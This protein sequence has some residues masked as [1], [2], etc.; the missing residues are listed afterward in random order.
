MNRKAERVKN[1]PAR[2]PLALQSIF[3]KGS[4]GIVVN[5]PP[6]GNIAMKKFPIWRWRSDDSKPN[7][8]VVAELSTND[9]LISEARDKTRK[10][11]VRES[12][13]EQLL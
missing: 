3:L 5:V 4:M 1:V 13:F 2:I 10:K 12:V 8:S 11:R 7:S 9:D 6:P